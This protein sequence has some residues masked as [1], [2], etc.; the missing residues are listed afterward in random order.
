M[1]TGIIIQARINSTRF[2]AKIFAK[3][4]D[5]FVLQHVMNAAQETCLPWTLAIPHDEEVLFRVFCGEQPNII[6]GPEDDVL[7]RFVIAAQT[8]NFNHIIRITSDCPLIPPG[9][10]LACLEKYVEEEPG[11]LTTTFFDPRVYSVA[12]GLPSGFDVEIFSLKNLLIADKHARNEEREHVTLYFKRNLASQIFTPGNLTLD[13]KA[14]YSV[15]TKED[16]ER[17]QTIMT[18]HPK[19]Y[20]IDE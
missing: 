9:L 1:T 12:Q 18:E 13:S 2:K 8:Y 7:A 14:K 6:E 15:D 4:A 5:S 10:I 20:W 19:P 11:Y 3:L 16:L 17:I